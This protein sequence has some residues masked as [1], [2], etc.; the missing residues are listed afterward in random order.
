M[1]KAP[2]P[3]EAGLIAFAIVDELVRRL[4]ARGAFAGDDYRTI[5]ESVEGTFAKDERQ[6]VKDCVNRIRKMSPK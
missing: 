4:T 1:N 5:L 2:A 6:K 3:P